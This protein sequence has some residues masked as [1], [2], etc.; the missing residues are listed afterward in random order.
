MLHA[1]F[2]RAAALCIPLVLANCMDGTLHRDALAA[3][4]KRQM[5]GMSKE[6]VLACMGPPKKKAAEGTTEV[7]SYQVSDRSQTNTDNIKMNSFYTVKPTTHFKKFCIVN[8]VMKEGVVK[9]INYLGPAATTPFNEN[10]QCG[11][12]VAAC[13][14]N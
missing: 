11:Y 12:A 13:V 6:E 10:D 7:W 5:V 9:K 14:E 8:V 1:R 4:A 2:L 3:K